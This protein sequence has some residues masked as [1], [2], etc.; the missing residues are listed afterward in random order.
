M[1]K[2]TIIAV[3]ISV[4]IIT[5]FMIINYTFF[6][7]QIP[8]TTKQEKKEVQEVV[9][10]K[11]EPH[12]G[13]MIM[14]VETEGL[15][16][17][18]KIYS[19]NEY[20]ITFLTRGGLIKSIKLKNYKD[21]DGSPIEM[22]VSGDTNEY[23]FG[24]R[25][26]NYTTENDLFHFSS[27]ESENKCEFY[28]QYKIVVKEGEEE[29]ESIITLKKTLAF[30]DNY[31]LEFNI[32][33]IEG[34]NNN[35][36]LKYEEIPLSEKK[37]DKWKPKEL[38]YTLS[39][40]PQIGPP[41]EKIDDK[42]D[43]R[44]YVYAKNYKG[45]KKDITGDV[46]KN[47]KMMIKDAPYW[48]AIEGK[49]FVVIARPPLDKFEKEQIGFDIS[50][51][52][53]IKEHSGFFFNRKYEELPRID[54]T[55]KFYIGP[56][57]KDILKIHADIGFDKVIGENFLLDWLSE[58]LKLLLTFIHSMV[59]N[60]GVAIIL[61]TII[62]KI[63]FFPLTQKGF[64]S[65][66]KMQ[67]LNP[68]IEELKAKYKEN[69][70]KLN[71]E[72]AA[73]YKKEGIN[74]LMGCLPM[75][76]QLPIFFALYGLLGNYFELRG[77]MFIPGWITDLSSPE[78][79]LPLHFT[80]PFLNWSDIRALPFIMVATF[81]VQQKITQSPSSTTNQM[82]LLMYAMPLI[83]FFILYEMPSGLVLY[84]TVQNI[85]SVFQQIYINYVQKRRGGKGIV[86]SLKEELVKKK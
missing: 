21:L 61:M 72:M 8:Q 78:S 6:Q 57:I 25:F 71:A 22:I 83:F 55:Y 16:D 49:Y 86:T 69:P 42:I 70:Q 62:I 74:P 73:L 43:K 59:K 12:G 18:E 51:I 44:R 19:R 66:T 52:Q 76:I 47:K 23:P 30:K 29:K 68:K 31:L 85:L 15:V 34:E 80:I 9:E 77:A 40:G 64:K 14:P 81:F 63:I 20:D 36:L 37:D 3:I 53:G 46:R 11:D 5:V 10:D 26:G 38:M 28:R 75:L 32:S 45:D 1:D 7:P 65:T 58:L 4:A 39:F 17:E 27:N 56:M 33:I 50:Q 60:W 13:M 82:K 41:V 84:W 54:D 24:I 79:I 48:V 67:A 35:I 2:N